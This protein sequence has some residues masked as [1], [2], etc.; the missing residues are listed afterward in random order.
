MEIMRKFVAEAARW[1]GKEVE[2]PSNWGGYEGEPLRIEFWQGRP[3]RLHDRFL[4][5][6]SA[7]DNSWKLERLAP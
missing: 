2:R 4:Y 5:T 6:F 7:Q 3:S 1:M